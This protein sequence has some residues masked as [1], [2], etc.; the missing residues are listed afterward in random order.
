MGPLQGIGSNLPLPRYQ[1]LWGKLSRDKTRSHPLVCHMLDVAEMTRALWRDALTAG[2]RARWAYALGMDDSA[3]DRLLAFWAALHDL[4]KASPVFQR[5]WRE[6]EVSLNAAGLPFPKRF[7]DEICPHGLIT[8]TTL[9]A[10][11]TAD[12]FLPASAAAQIARARGPPRHVAHTRRRA[13]GQKGRARRRRLGRRAARVIQRVTRRVAATTIDV[14]AAFRSCCQQRFPDMVL[15][16][17]QR[18][19]LAWLHGRAFLLC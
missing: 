7:V 4:G 14:L 1:L 18:S 8:T 3:A 2:Q 6:A 16:F 10:M 9:P 19:R 15:R 17:G 5:Q 12:T 11:L 13:K